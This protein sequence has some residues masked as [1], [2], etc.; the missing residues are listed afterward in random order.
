MEIKKIYFDMD[1]VLAD[2]GRGITE[3]CGLPFVDQDKQTRSQTDAM[4]AAM[5]KVPHFY[6]Q[7]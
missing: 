3:L 1:G 2:F 4:F 7:L 5:K 6:D